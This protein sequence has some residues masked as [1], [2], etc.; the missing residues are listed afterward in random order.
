MLQSHS[1][2]GSRTNQGRKAAATSLLFHIPVPNY[3]DRI[4]WLT[5]HYLLRLFLK[6][7]EYKNCHDDAPLLGQRQVWDPSRNGVLCTC[8]PHRHPRTR[9]RGHDRT[10]EL[11]VLRRRDI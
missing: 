1:L 2:P 7:T 8:T 9:M 6:T 11:L 10:Q 4:A 3:P 5:R